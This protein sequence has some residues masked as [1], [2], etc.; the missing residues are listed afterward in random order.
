MKVSDLCTYAPKSPIKA[1][2]AVADGKYMFFTS[3][4]DETKRYNDYQ[5]DCEGIIMGTGGNATLHYYNGKFATSTDCVVLL[6]NET[7]R[8]KYLYYFFLYNTALLEAGFKGAGL[9]H[10]NKTYISSIEL[11]NVPSVEEQDK[12]IEVLDKVQA[13]VSGRMTVLSKL[14]KLIK[15]RF[16]ELFDLCNCRFG[17]FGEDTDFVDYRG[18]TPE[19]SDAGTIRMVN[20]KSV[21]KGFFKDINEYVTEET[22]DEWM[23]RGFGYPGDVLFVTEGHTFGNT[24]QVP[25][26]L[27][28]FALGQ[29]VITIKGHKNVVNNSFLCGYMQTDRF[30]KDIVAYRTGGTAQGIRSKDLVKV[31][32]PL[33]DYEQQLAFDA[34]VK[35]VDKSKVVVQEALDKAQLL[36]ES[37]MQ[38]YFG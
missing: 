8:C 17:T 15:A 32:I 20:A 27:T 4:S 24:C 33:P 28:K 25:E 12:V 7:I 18:K 1:G 10:T 13:V 34:F 11:P 30:F 38:E 23:H 36:F 26:Y 22:Y 14:D 6:P 29:R 3:S 5:L 35:Q 31:Q 16:V 2:E 9:K 19:L 21:G 37:L